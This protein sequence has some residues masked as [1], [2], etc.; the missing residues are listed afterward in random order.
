MTTITMDANCVTMINVFTVKPE[1][2]QQLLDLLTEL[3]TNSMRHLPG[4]I[5]ASI[6][7]SL[8]RTQVAVYGQ[9]RT[10]TDLRNM[11]KVRESIPHLQAA[12]TLM[13]GAESK[14]YEVVEVCKRG[15][16]H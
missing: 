4:F 14:V 11:V 2:Q 8:D 12:F 15:G 5:S 7:K 1:K 13:N 9:W 6:H 3:T 10:L 16:K